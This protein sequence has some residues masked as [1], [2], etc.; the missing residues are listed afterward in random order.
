MF[1]INHEFISSEFVPIFLFLIQV[2]NL[3]TEILFA[4]FS[5]FSLG[6][7]DFLYKLSHKWEVKPS[8]FMLFQNFSF[9]PAAFGVAYYREELIWNNFLLLGFVNGF[10]AFSAFLFVLFSLKN[11]AAISIVT[12]VRLNFILT[13]LLA[14]VFL[15]E[16]LSL[17]KML[18]IFLCIIAILSI[19]F[20]KSFLPRDKS[21]F[22]Y[23]LLSMCLFGLIGFFIKLSLSFGA[24]PS[25]MILAQTFGVFSLTIP[26]VFMRREK[27]PQIKLSLILPFLCGILTYASYLSLSFAL[28]YGEAIVV[29]PIAQLSFVFT[30]IL[31][32]LFFKERLSLKKGLGISFAILAVL[33]LSF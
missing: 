24:L 33:I 1:Y 16:D 18:A 7:S 26:Y 30:G 19:G 23:A 21:S 4:L 15:G 9:L 13:S 14:I 11:S 5:L 12:I 2:N 28:V 10:M 17:Y 8:T 32:V 20:D 6:C 22:Y 25:G 31:S 3:K 27:L 29:T